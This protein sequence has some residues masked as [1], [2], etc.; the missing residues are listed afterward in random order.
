MAF[1]KQEREYQHAPGIE[2][3]LEDVIGGGTVDRSDMAGALFAGRPLDEL[4]PL[5][6]VVK[7]EATGAFRV[8]K[9]A[10][11]YEAASAAKY[12][13]QKKHLFVVGDTVTLG[14]DYTKASDVIKDIDKSDPK[15]DVIT[16]AATIGAA[17]EGDV[18]VLAKDKQAAGSAVPKYGGKAAEVYLTMSPI[19]LTVANGSSGLLVMGT[20]TEAAM[21]LPMDAAL[22]ARTRIHFV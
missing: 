17:S 9:T 10:R 1:L 22:K 5:A 8:I 12:K 11:V 3:I 13:V 15:F 20:V 16:L 21:L 2:K 4:P 19:D 6:P 14:G 7:D 18:L